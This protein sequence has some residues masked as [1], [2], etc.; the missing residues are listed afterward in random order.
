M[1]RRSSPQMHRESLASNHNHRRCLICDSSSLA[2]MVDYKRVTLVRCRG[3]G[4]V[5]SPLIPTIEELVRHYEG[6]SRS[7]I[8]NSPVSIRRRAE[9]VTWFNS[10]RQTN[11][12][13]DVGCGVGDLL[14]QA[15]Q[16]GWV[17]YGTEF[18]QKALDICTRK[19]HSMA[20]GP[21]ELSNYQRESFDVV[22][23]SEVVEHI[24]NHRE[25]FRRVQAILR[26]GGLLFITTP[27]FNSF[28]RRILGDRWNVIQYPEHLAYF[29]PQTLASLMELSGFEKVWLKTT[30]I[31]VTRFLTSMRNPREANVARRDAHS[32]DE[33]ARV[34]LEAHGMNVVKRTVNAM[35]D[36]TQL[37]DSIKA[38]FMKPKSRLFG[39]D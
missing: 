34:L 13:L 25:E 2:A 3:C 26:P 27:N 8:F 15:K 30:G 7:T 39:G 11:R 9:W 1:D 20:A 33:A 12:I 24:N 18:T 23:Y 5:F 14:D 37:G 19:G 31:S 17:T 35:L 32:A 16:A 22:V 29:T 10:Y 36:K 38:A 6:Y 28:S 21:L 4:L